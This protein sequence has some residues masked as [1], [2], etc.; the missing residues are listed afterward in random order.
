MLKKKLSDCIATPSIVAATLQLQ[1]HVVC[2]SD[3]I[4]V[5]VCVCFRVTQGSQALGEPSVSRDLL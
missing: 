1:S 5:C 4:L 2:S 3:I